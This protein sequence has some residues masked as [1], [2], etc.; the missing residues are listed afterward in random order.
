MIFTDGRHKSQDFSV[1]EF[2]LLEK[3]MEWMGW[4][5][6]HTPLL[7]LWQLMHHLNSSVEEIQVFKNL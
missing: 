5:T 3:M 1:R 6:K 2:L 4:E 7:P